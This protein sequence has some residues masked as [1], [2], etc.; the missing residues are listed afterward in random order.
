MPFITPHISI[1]LQLIQGLAGLCHTWGQGTSAAAEGRFPSSLF[2]LILEYRS[3]NLLRFGDTGITVTL[4]HSITEFLPR[5]A[6]NIDS[7]TQL[8]YFDKKEKL[9]CIEFLKLS[10]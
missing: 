8:A 2:N 4:G 6:M 5:H 7:M 9:L 3:Q 1:T 10:F